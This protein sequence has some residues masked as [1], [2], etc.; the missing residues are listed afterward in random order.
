MIVAALEDLARFAGLSPAF[1]RA[2]AW[3]AEGSWRGL[4]DGRYEVDGNRVYALLM[5]VA[6]KGAAEL[7]LE[8]HRRYADI[9][10]GISGGEW[11]LCRDVRGLRSAEAYSQEK[12]IEFFQDGT[13]AHRVELGSGIAA[14][15][16]PEDAH[17]PCVAPGEAGSVRKLVVKVAVA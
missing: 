17:K 1:D 15:F 16:F 14:V 9:Q 2:I 12:D 3:I 5:T 13:G 7:R 6:T 8:A 4:E 11:I 10:V